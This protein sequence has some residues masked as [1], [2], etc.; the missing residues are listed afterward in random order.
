MT[1]ALPPYPPNL[2]KLRQRQIAIARNF[3]LETK[4]IHPKKNN[5]KPRSERRTL[6]GFPAA[7][8]LKT[9][10]CRQGVFGTQPAEL[11]FESFLT[12]TLELSGPRQRLRL[13]DLLC[14]LTLG[15]C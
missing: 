8:K 3:N 13:N 7:S 2:D 5:N 11:G 4:E 6:V 15:R 12:L 10:C 14:Y 9:L 1:D